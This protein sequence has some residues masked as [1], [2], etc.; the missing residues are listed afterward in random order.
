MGA[1]AKKLDT[2]FFP[3][4]TRIFFTRTNIHMMLFFKLSNNKQYTVAKKIRLKINYTN[5]NFSQKKS[6]DS[7]STYFQLDFLIMNGLK[8]EISS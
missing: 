7:S 8:N 3:P 6:P 2:S 1:N 5:D 4:I